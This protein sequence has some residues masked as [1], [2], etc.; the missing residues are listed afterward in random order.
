MRQS[1]LTVLA[2]AA[3]ACGGPAP[4]APL[5]QVTIPPGASFRAI[6]ESLSAHQVLKHPRWFEFLARIQGSDRSAQAGIYELRHGE[7]ATTL[8]RIL[9]EGRGKLVRFTV[10]EGETLRTVAGLAEE[11]LGIAADSFRAAT[12][13]TVRLRAAGAEGPSYE[14]WLHPETYLVPIT[15]V[16]EDLVDLMV[17]QTVA[18]WTPERE[19]R[20][21]SM[22]MTW[23][24]VLTLASIVEG[25]ALVDDERPVIAGV[26]LNR[27]RLRMALQAD[28][29]VQYGIELST[30]ERKSRLYTKDYKFKS[31]Y[32]TYLA[33]GLPPGPI[34]SPGTASIDAVLTPA[35]VPYLFFVAG[36]DRRHV[37]SRTYREHL[38]AIR[39]VRAGVLPP[40]EMN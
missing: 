4:D 27:L 13:D 39:R 11:Q 28:P 37:F 30:G 16:P 5:E 6:S 17:R 31:P 15:I 29:T 26:Y 1:L 32:N 18:L 23:L 35:S 14:G 34:N 2:T 36:P 22:R 19:A 8:L 3:I 21:D 33:P 25:E 9:T 20:R 10:P 38:T 40:P 24:E 12:R 7:S